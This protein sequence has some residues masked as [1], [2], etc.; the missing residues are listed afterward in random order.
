MTII[1][2]IQTD[3]PQNLSIGQQV[4][5]CYDEE[6]W[7][8][9]SQLQNKP[10][11]VLLLQQSKPNNHLIE[12]EGLKYVI[13]ADCLFPYLTTPNKKKI[14]ATRRKT[15]SRVY[16]YGKNNHSHMKH[17]WFNQDWV[18]NGIWPY[19]EKAGKAI[20]PALLSF[21]HNQWNNPS[22]LY[23]A[24][25]VG[26]SPQTVR[27]GFKA[28]EGFPGL[29]IKT[30]RTASGHI[31]KRFNYSREHT[32]KEYPFFDRIIS[33]GL[34]YSLPM[35]SKCLYPVMR[36]YV[37]RFDPE[38]YEC[39]LLAIDELSDRVGELDWVDDFENAYFRR[40]FDICNEKQNLLCDYAGIHRDS[41]YKAISGLIDNFLV[42]VSDNG[43]YLVFLRPHHYWKAKYMN[44]RVNND[45][46]KYFDKY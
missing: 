29:E 38:E 19:L 37:I 40:W 42:R 26:L 8:I 34:W 31:G 24:S 7:Q 2:Q 46:A 16:W 44:E 18:F 17:F 30:Y 21:P 9:N 14:K 41:F 6:K 28:L 33:G 12:I 10:G 11:T 35:V 27:K 43:G 25:L 23:I 45:L 15:T 20:L 13:P 1:K 39:E 22:E 36:S 3:I 5:V 4:L 32:E